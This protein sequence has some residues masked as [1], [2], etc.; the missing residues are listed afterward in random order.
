MYPPFTNRWNFETE[1][2]VQRNTRASNPR[3]ADPRASMPPPLGD[4][5]QMPEPRSSSGIAS[6]FKSLTGGKITKSPST[7]SPATGPLQ[8][9]NGSIPQK[10]SHGGAFNHEPSLEQLQAGHSLSDRISAAEYLRRAVIDYP[11]EKCRDLIEPTQTQQARIA[12]FELLTACVQC[13]S[14]NDPERASFFRV[15]SHP[16]TREDFHLQLVSLIE[17]SRH[18][19]DLSGFHYDLLP[20][21][22]LWLKDTWSAATSE[23]NARKKATRQNS[24]PKEPALSEEESNLA[25]LFAFIADIIKFSSNIVTE[26]T[27]SQLLSQILE[28]CTS[29]ATETDL[30]ACNQ[31]FD[32]VITYGD[33]PDSKLQPVVKVLCSIHSSLWNVHQDAWRCIGNL[34]KSHHGLTM[35]RILIEI[36]EKPLLDKSDDKQY[37]QN[38]KEVRGAIS[39][40][41]KFVTDQPE[42][43]EAFAVT[44]LAYVRE[45][46]DI[47]I[48]QEFIDFAVLMAEQTRDES[49]FQHAIDV[50]R[51]VITSDRMQSPLGSPSGSHHGILSSKSGSSSATPS[52]VHSPSNVVV[53]GLIRVF[54]R[55]MFT[56]IPK[57]LRVFEELLAIAQASD[58]PTD[59]R[60]SALKM[61]FRLRADAMNRIFLTPFTESDALAASLYR[62]AES[63]ASKHAADDAA[64]Q[65]RVARADEFNSRL[66]RSTSGGQ[67]Q[68]LPKQPFRLG[69]GMNRA[70]QRNH[71]MWMSPDPDAL[72]D[73]TNGNATLRLVSIIENIDQKFT[74]QDLHVA[75]LGSD[76][77]GLQELVAHSNAAEA[78]VTEEKTDLITDALEDAFHTPI[79]SMDPSSTNT[80]EK[81][82]WA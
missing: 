66:A 40:L 61:F 35:V 7:Q 58:C 18:G 11:V 48:L 20:L 82:A 12:G 54:M 16:T 36:L 62:T 65:S 77:V 13:A 22:T 42:V 76:Q 2:R 15:L 55:T 6:V 60:I 32:A 49:L 9:D 47:A 51:S 38:I 72:P 74:A 34:C 21:L 73:T 64:Q 70:L 80:E 81:R 25:L 28:I 52:I 24:L 43:F 79:E 59:S 44:V 68:S 8:F 50:M 4:A 41:E 10:L 33:I 37:S 31:V 78:S 63:L 14:S 23:R 27:S 5:A 45:E 67:A 30:K 19:K 29:S 75:D 57:S 26:P 39:A 56:E 69:S 3:A 17:L 71:Q 46:K 53:K 1:S